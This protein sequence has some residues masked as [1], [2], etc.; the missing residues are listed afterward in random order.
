MT[1]GEGMAR[2]RTRRRPAEVDRTVRECI[3][4]DYLR[5]TRRLLLLDYDGTL[6]PFA[7]RPEKAVPGK[8]LLRL[9]S[10]LSSLPRNEVTLISG[11]TRPELENWFGALNL[12]LVAEHGAWLRPKGRKDWEMAIPLSAAWKEKLRP[13][14]CSFL[15]RVPGSLLEEKDLSFAWHYRNAEP[16]IGARRARALAAALRRAGAG[17]RLEVLE[18]AKV[19][20]MK[21]QAVGKGKAALRLLRNDRPGF[22]LAIGDD[23]T[24]E[25]MFCALPGRAYTI[26]VGAAASGAGFFFPS[27]AGVLPF[28]RRLRDADDGGSGVRP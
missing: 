23:P 13:L 15:D 27:R 3:V 10:D 25:D 26:K 9:L 11:R 18:G 17:M 1:T 20:E 7:S 14:F 28:L 4:A 8:K 2:C 12:T 6:V 19:V 24:D 16:R 5:S 21:N 22:I